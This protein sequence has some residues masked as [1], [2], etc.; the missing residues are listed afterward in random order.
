MRVIDCKQSSPEWYQARAGI[1]TASEFGRLLTPK[2]LQFS[3]AGAR[4]Y[5]CE[6]IAARL[7]GCPPEGVE[8]Y[9]TRAMQHGIDTEKDARGKLFKDY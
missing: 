9:T 4:S 1:P 6:L 2:K 7:M 8:S 3:K 5:A